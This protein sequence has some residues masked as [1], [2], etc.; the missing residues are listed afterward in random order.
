[1]A[2]KVENGCRSTLLVEVGELPAEVVDD[3][4]GADGVDAGEQNEVAVAVGEQQADGDR[5]PSRG[6]GPDPAYLRGRERG[7]HS[8]RRVR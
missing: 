7:W 8:S 5:G 1:M 6:A 2:I 3:A 4:V